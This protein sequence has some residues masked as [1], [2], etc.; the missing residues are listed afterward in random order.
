M[1]GQSTES[2][3]QSPQ[4]NQSADCCCLLH[5]RAACNVVYC[6][7]H[8]PNMHAACSLPVA[9]RQRFMWRS[10]HSQSVTFG[11]VQR[12]TAPFVSYPFLSSRRSGAMS[13]AR[14]FSR[15]PQSTSTRRTS[16]NPTLQQM[17]RIQ[18]RTESNGATCRLALQRCRQPSPAQPSPAQP[19]P[20][21]PIPSQRRCVR[22]TAAGPAPPACTL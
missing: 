6:M 22:L 11:H 8:A 21:Q 2:P 13:T 9:L 3:M 5:L 7:Q 19:S 20:A 1:S 12:S 18:R 15:Q 4:R 17:H 16:A 14:A 10:L